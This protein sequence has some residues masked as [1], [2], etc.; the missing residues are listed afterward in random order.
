MNNPAIKQIVE[1]NKPTLKEEKIYRINTLLDRLVQIPVELDYIHEKL[2]TGLSRQ[3][4]IELV[5]KRSDL[6]NE[7]DVKERE[8]KEIYQCR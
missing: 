3:E 5:A 1:M 4:F 8:L 6:M 7:Y 2:H